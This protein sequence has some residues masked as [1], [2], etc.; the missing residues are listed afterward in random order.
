MSCFRRASA[1]CHVGVAGLSEKY[2]MIISDHRCMLVELDTHST[3]GGDLLLEV[4]IL[5]THCLRLLFWLLSE[6]C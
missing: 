4:I 6:S 3:E 5:V 1:W 2:I